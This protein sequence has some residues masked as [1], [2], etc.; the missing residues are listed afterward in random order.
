MALRSAEL[1]RRPGGSVSV[2]YM[3]IETATD[4]G[5]VLLRVT[6]SPDPERKPP[7]IVSREMLSVVL[8]LFLN[9]GGSYEQAQAD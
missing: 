7:L 1:S 5:F 9:G 2:L 3:H 6:A 4:P 8:H